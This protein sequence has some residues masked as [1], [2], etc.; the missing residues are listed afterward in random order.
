MSRK[1]P[2]A[3]ATVAALFATSEAQA[4]EAAHTGFMARVGIGVDYLAGSESLGSVSVSASGFGATLHLALGGYVIPNLAVHATLWGGTA[5][6]PSLSVT[7][8]TS[9]TSGSS[10]DASLTASAFGV[11]ATYVIT[12]IELFLSGSVG[13]SIVRFSSTRGSVSATAETDLG[14]ALNV[15][16]G[17]QWLVTPNWGVGVM[18]QLAWQTNPDSSSAGTSYNFNTFQFG[19][20]F[21]AT[22]N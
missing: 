10:T 12:P 9:T 21:S 18:G 20:L 1:L 13:A 15:A 22:Y 4:Q 14:F 11:G 5:I 2:L 7:S 8:G 6:N 16:A 19:L 17:K 3:I